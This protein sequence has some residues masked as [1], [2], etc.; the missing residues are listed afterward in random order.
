MPNR[1]AAVIMAGGLGTRMRSEL[2]KHLH[3]LLGKRVVDWVIDAA[4]S[5]DPERLVVVIS[6]GRAAD[7]DG[8]EIAV[9]EEPLGTG[10]AAAAARPALDGFQGAVLVVPG[11]AALATADVLGELVEAHRSAG[12]A[13][14]LLSFTSPT[15]L[16][17]GR[18][19]RDADGEVARIVEEKDASPEERAIEELNSSFYVFEADALWPALERLDADN[20]QGELYLTDAV[21]GIVAAGARV[22]AHRSQADPRAFVGIAGRMM[23]L[24]PLPHAGSRGRHE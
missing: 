16:P 19:V 7:Y 5:L 24:D 11:D 10:D 3:P 9:Q 8:V 13:A 12:P 1:I 23:A 4:R 22:V 2:P 21:E 17:Y 20:A 15:P 18:I 6:P 14:T